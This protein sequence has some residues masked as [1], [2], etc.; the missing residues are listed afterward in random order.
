MVLHYGPHDALLIVDPQVD[1]CPGGALPVP[2]GDRI[3]EAVNRV[4]GGIPLVV[5]S[6]DWHPPG[7][8]SFRDQGGPWP[9][10]CRQGTPGA[11][12][13]PAL[14]RSPIQEIFSCGAEVDLDGYSAFE[15]TELAAWLRDRSVRRLFVAGLAT[16]YCVRASVL[17]ACREGFDVVVLEDGI[18]AIDANP[19]DGDRAL[20][21]MRA[22]GAT[23]AQSADVAGSTP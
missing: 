11:E 10:H 5:A 21:E 9:V 18:A 6:R 2:G 23:V 13:H 7:H 1:F 22:A 14:D 12:F 15:A 20:A 16:D 8:S 19:G 4:S 17:D 3:F